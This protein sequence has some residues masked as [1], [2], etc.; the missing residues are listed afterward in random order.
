MGFKVTIKKNFDFSRLVPKVR[1]KFADAIPSP[2]RKEILDTLNSGK[3]PVKGKKFRQ[4]SAK[5]A[6][7]NKGGRRRPVTLKDEGDL[8]DSLKI[9]VSRSKIRITFEDFKAKFHNDDGAGR[10]KVIRRMLPTKSGE[11]FRK[12][13]QPLPSIVINGVSTE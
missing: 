12:S 13:I 11:T 7:R 9:K 6:S 2:L 8:H 4:Y 3:S 5:Y 10:S 1:K